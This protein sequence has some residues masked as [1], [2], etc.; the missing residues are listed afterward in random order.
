MQSCSLPNKRPS[1]VGRAPSR[2]FA[3]HRHLRHAPIASKGTCLRRHPLSTTCVLRRGTSESWRAHAPQVSAPWA[4][5]SRKLL[6]HK[7]SLRLAELALLLCEGFWPPW[8][9]LPPCWTKCSARQA[10]SPAR[11]SPARTCPLHTPLALAGSNPTLRLPLL[12]GFH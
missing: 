5:I 8:H 6:C 7:L 10:C 3:G 9:V 4:K 11:L 2:S 1:V 12:V